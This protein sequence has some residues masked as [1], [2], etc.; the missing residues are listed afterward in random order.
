[1]FKNTKFP[2]YYKIIII[3]LI[4]IIFLLELISSFFLFLK[5]DTDFNKIFI[6]KWPTTLRLSNKDLD[7]L[8]YKNLQ[9][10]KI[11]DNFKYSS[12]LGFFNSKYISIWV[13][14]KNKASLDDHENFTE[15]LQKYKGKNIFIALGGSTTAS[16]QSSNWPSHISKKL[17][18][19]HI[20]INAGHNG[21]MSYQER[22]LLNEILLPILKNYK[23][24]NVVSLSGTNDFSY[25]FNYYLAR[26][27]YKINN[28]MS[29]SNIP[30][31]FYMNDV[32][33]NEMINK[34][35]NLFKNFIISSSTLKRLLPATS[36]MITRQ[37]Y[38]EIK[39]I[40]SFLGPQKKQRSNLMRYCNVFVSIPWSAGPI[41]PGELL[42]KKE[43]KLY[44]DISDAMK[45]KK[46]IL[47]RKEIRE[48]VKNCS[49]KRN[50]KLAKIQYK[51]FSKK[52]FDDVI[53]KY[54]NNHADTFNLLKSKGIK[55]NVFLQPI[56]I[57]NNR[58]IK[59]I[60][61][62]DYVLV[63]WYKNGG[64][65]GYLYK[66]PGIKAFQ[67]ASN[68]ITKTGLSYIFDI[69]RIFYE[70]PID[71]FTDDNIHYTNDGSNIIADEILKNLR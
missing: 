53:K 40:W 10:N 31:I 56:K 1:M 25:N 30:N 35:N 8:F 51:D 43:S 32:L 54:F 27:K 70:K 5:N 52:E 41:T 13:N 48:N 66:I 22:V 57:D 29:F 42:T 58:I 64:A 19:S 20:V 39:P 62:Y 24:T 71:Y 46:N 47:D 45:G 33:F 16:S 69:H 50:K 17:R 36:Y 23:I 6:T 4:I 11:V 7:L 2:T 12:L 18:N 60:P 55:Y 21:Y 37:P 9:K 49:L 61:N 67:E 14:G 38:K 26:E 15:I 28:Q 65:N 3:N 34:K 44:N 68:K 59:D 63:H